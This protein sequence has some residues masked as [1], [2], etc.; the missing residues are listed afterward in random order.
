MVASPRASRR[1]APEHR[2]LLIENLAEVT[3]MHHQVAGPAAES[4]SEAREAAV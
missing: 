1:F 3:R 2:G 4:P